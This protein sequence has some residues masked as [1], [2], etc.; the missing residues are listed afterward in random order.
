MV[1]KLDINWLA[2]NLPLEERQALLKKLIEHSKLSMDPLFFDD[3]IS[4]PAINIDTEFAV[5]PWFSRLWYRLLGFFRHQ[6]SKKIFWDKEVAI[7]GKKI[8]KKYPGLY[9]YQKDM[10]LPYFYRNI[11]KL[12]EAA[13]FFYSA[14][15]AGVNRDREAFFAFLGSLEMPNVHRR[16]QEETDPLFIVKKHI[17]P[18]EAELRQLAFRA[19]EDNLNII[20]KEQ[21][22]AMYS[23]AR[24]LLCLKELSSFS[25]DRF[26]N[27]F[28]SNRGIKGLSCSAAVVKDFLV[29]LNN[30]LIS[31][32]T[33]PSMT[34]LESLFVFILQGRAGEPGLNAEREINLLLLRAEDALAVIRDFNKQ[35]PITWILRCATRDLSFSPGE[36]SG[37]E[38]WFVVYR[39]Y[40]RKHIEIS[41]ADYSR[42]RREQ[43]LLNSFRNFL[44][45]ES[46]RTLENTRTRSNPDG[47]PIKGAF[48]I[49]FIYTFCS[50]V[51]VSDISQILYLIFIGAEFRKEEDRIEFYG[52]YNYLIT[53]E[54]EIKN[55]EYRISLSGDHGRS[56]A[57]ARN[58]ITAPLVK[59]RRLQAIIGKVQEEAE[60]ILEQSRGAAASMLGILMGIAGKGRAG[61]R[62]N[63][64]YNSAS[65]ASRDE[66]F[67]PGVN[68]TITQL[69]TL[70]KLL[71]EIDLMENGR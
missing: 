37:G 38:D 60:K 26:I 6:P 30:I 62:D 11:V 3:H 22:S 21:R 34:L 10:L 35:N 32:K 50:A 51:F 47:M 55:F 61:S 70:I 9:D 14:L 31:L 29:S 17:A 66:N 43:G 2:S 16:L 13:Q 23:A 8:E 12:K 33:V 39:D 53:L 63:I 19:L 40:W 52:A 15:D 45:G 20:N 67:I 56:Y 41:L 71:S 24:S 65:L 5:L 25:F 4:A 44:K 7:L 1:E 57:Q 69:E 18:A 36:I 48:A 28:G 59:F 27:L 42:S 54:E 49:S 58:D 46:L 64:L 68:R